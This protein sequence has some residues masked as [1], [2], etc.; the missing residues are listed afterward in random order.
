[1]SSHNPSP[2]DLRADKALALDLIHAAIGSVEP[3]SA[4]KRYVRRDGDFLIIGDKTF[5][6]TEIENLFVVGAGKA[7]GPMALAIEEIVGDRITDGFVNVKYG[8]SV[9]T[10]HIRINEAGHP[11]PD[12]R[13]A[14]GAEEILAIC[15][16]AGARDL[17]I[18]VISGGGSALMMLPVDGVSLND[19]RRITDSLLR[20][21]ATINEF[22]AVRKHLSKIK[23]GGLCRE[24][25]PA[26]VVT[27]VMS[28]VV[29]SPL[30]VIASG[31]TVPDTST[32]ADAWEAIESNG[33]LDRLPPSIHEHLSRGLAGDIPETPKPGDPIFKRTQNVLI[34][35]NEIAAGALIRRAEARSLNTMLLSTFVEGGARD[36]GIMLA[37][38]AREVATYGRPIAR[39]ACFVMSGETTVAVRG[40]GLGGRNQE[41]VLAAA[42]KI[43]GLENVM[44][45]SC[46]TDGIDGPTDAAGAFAH[47]GTVRAARE[48]KMDPEQ[49]L[50]DNDSYHF[51]ER[52]GDLIVIGQTNTN[53][54]DLMFA[55]IL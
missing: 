39:P 5:D 14:Q 16:R 17:V 12:E 45:V 2:R 49:F 22:N 33:L 21:G 31:P 23:G 40:R 51:F 25:G 36:V 44:I 32:F 11:I 7:A 53:V 9:Q 20:S 50:S 26:E 38:I 41:L 54:A 35:S 52:I 55:L 3:G 30:D 10:R 15:R 8:S 37:A 46:A 13:S 29:G 24:A 19:K 6:L 18:C 28:D 34:G 42:T 27:L 43:D 48:Q 4:V 1:M 47:G